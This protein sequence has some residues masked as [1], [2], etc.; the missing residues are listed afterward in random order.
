MLT[1]VWL[2]VLILP[3]FVFIILESIF[4]FNVPS[5][6]VFLGL[7]LLSGNKTIIFTVSS[8]L[9]KHTTDQA[10][11][12]DWCHLLRKYGTN[13]CQNQ[14]LIDC[15]QRTNKE[16]KPNPT[17]YFVYYKNSICYNKKLLLTHLHSERPKE[18]WWF[19]KY[20]LTKAFFFENIWSRNVDQ[21]TNN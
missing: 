13:W 4:L 15:S 1:I 7:G 20:S 11:Q 12:G 10:S 3:Y 19:W 17:T 18:A 16:I 14:L 6:L 2:D 9:S 21:D 5:T 8:I